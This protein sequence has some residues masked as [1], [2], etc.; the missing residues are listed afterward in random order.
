MM[1]PGLWPGFCLHWSGLLKACAFHFPTYTGAILSECRPSNDARLRPLIRDPWNLIR[2]APAKGNKG[3]QWVAAPGRNKL[4]RSPRG[5]IRPASLCAQEGAC[6]PVLSP[7]PSGGVQQMRRRKPRLQFCSL[8]N[9]N[10]THRFITSP[11]TPDKQ[12]PITS[13]S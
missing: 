7:C 8:L 10:L 1:E 9:A 2:L 11:R 13:I 4:P 3:N 12:T 6:H 5:V